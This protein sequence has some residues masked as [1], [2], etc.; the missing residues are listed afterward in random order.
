MGNIAVDV[1]P[2]A[3]WQDLERLTH[4]IAKIKWKND[5][6]ER[7]GRGG[8]AQGGVD[9]LGYNF[10]AKEETGIQCK[11][12]ALKSKP[13]HESPSNT[14]T[15]SE[16]DQE[17]SEVRKSDH[18]LDHFIIATSG[19]RDAELQMYVASLNRKSVD[20]RVSIMFWDDYVEFLNDHPELMYRYYEN[21][22]KFRSEYSPL[23]HYLL[24]LSMAFD[25]PAL[26]TPFHCE[27][28]ATDFISAIAATQQAIATGCL[29]DR[30]NRVIDQVRLPKPKPKGLRAISN[31]LQKTRDLATEALAKGV[32]VEHANVIEI[33][34]LKLV[35]TL[36]NLRFDALQGLNE[37]LA[38][39]E[40]E[41][42]EFAEF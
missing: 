34:D 3:Y 18:V 17:L 12:R 1:F 25:R 31:K 23:N 13:S 36:N 40:L 2:P 24:M 19:P 4:D 22:L 42:V 38:E 39:N 7:H 33:L 32:I 10:V 9:V 16:I 35:D 11:K 41:I 27:S 26:R 37:I 28:R 5:Y 6:A 14:L 15:K 30:D 21:V 29:V 8:Q 20:I